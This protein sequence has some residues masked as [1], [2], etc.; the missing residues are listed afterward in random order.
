MNP[1]VI[2]VL[3]A[4]VAIILVIAVVSIRSQNETV[5]EERLGRYTELTFIPDAEEEKKNGKRN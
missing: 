4:V 2:I 3:V 1:I 5:V